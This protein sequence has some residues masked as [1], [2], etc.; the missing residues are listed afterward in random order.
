VVVWFRKPPGPV[1]SRVI[2]SDLDLRGPVACT[3]PSRRRLVVALTYPDGVQVWD[4]AANQHI[5]TI[6]E[7]EGATAMACGTLPNGHT[8]V[9]SRC[10]YLRAWDLNTGRVLWDEVEC[11]SDNMTCTTLNGRPVLV[12]SGPRRH[13]AFADDLGRG[14]L[15]GVQ[16]LDLASGQPVVIAGLDALDRGEMLSCS[17]VG[18][19]PVVITNVQYENLQAW[20]LATARPIGPLMRGS[21]LYG[22]NRAVCATRNGRTV[23]VST[24]TNTTSLIVLDLA[25]GSQVGPLLAHDENIATLM[26]TTLNRRSVI[27]SARHDGWISVWDLARGRERAR[28]Q[29][30]RVTGMAS[31]D[32]TLVV[33]TAEK[34]IA[35]DYPGLGPT[36]GDDVR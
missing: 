23:V 7:T 34:I 27:V 36:L 31:T 9:V 22:A 14:D 33:A 32:D 15:R 2:G 35:V 4:L 24:Q 28:M 13:N 29:V 25:T 1:A 3:G 11:D 16:V 18:N 26:G 6:F 21:G 30:T 19:R 10:G 5:G 8:A 20:D 17:M 12:V